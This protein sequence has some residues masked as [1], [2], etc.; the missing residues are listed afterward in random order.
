[1]TIEDHRGV[2]G[3][4]DAIEH[5]PPVRHHFRA[6]QTGRPRA[7]AKWAIDVSD[8]TIRSRHDITAAV[9][10]KASMP[11]SKSETE[12]TRRR[13]RSS[14]QPTDRGHVA[15][16]GDQPDTGTSARVRKCRNGTERPTSMADA[17][18]PCQQ[19]PIFR[20]C[21]RHAFRT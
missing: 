11:S 5:P 7:P 13:S 1:L 16:E 4:V 21:C 8:V 17:E 15:S 20:R 14:I 2:P 19:I 10:M 18:F 3:A 12:R 6:T 9:S